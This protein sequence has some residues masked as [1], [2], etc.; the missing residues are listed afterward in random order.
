MATISQQ[1]TELVN[2]KNALADN[3]VTKGVEASQSE[4]FNTLVPKVLDISSGGNNN[5]M[6]QLIDGSIT[7]LTVEDF[8]DVTSIRRSAF[9]YLSNL[10]KVS[11][12]SKITTINASAFANCTKLAD[13]NIPNSVTEIGVS[14]FE[15]C[16]AL[17][18]I[19][20]PSSITILR[21]NVLAYSGLESINI[22]S[23]ITKLENY[24]FYNCSKLKN[25]VLPSS[26]KD[27]GSA[28]CNICSNLIEATINSAIVGLNM[29]YSCSKLTTV[30]IYDSVERIRAN[31]FKNCSQCN[32]YIYNSTPPTLEASN[33][34][35]NVIAIYIPKGS[36][37]AYEEATNWYNLTEKFIEMEE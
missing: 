34:L 28:T 26:I 6:S 9:Y 1:L 36:L 37:T 4:T 3:L 31:A 29:F 14:A 30:R 8:G 19:K 21:S 11:I 22:P 25:I 2:Q 24:V 5:K 27:V 32:V 35:E 33:A 13:I 20:I 12:S 10:T 7:E 16:S 23:N 15:H 17:K 18:T